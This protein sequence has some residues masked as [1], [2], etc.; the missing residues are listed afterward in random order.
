MTLLLLLSGPLAV[1][2]SAI[3]AI[4]MKRHGFQKISSGKYLE[5]LAQ[6]RGDSSSRADLQALGDGLDAQTNFSWLIDDVAAPVIAAQPDQKCW[7]LDSVRKH[8]QVE[9]FRS[10]FGRHVFHTHLTAD[11][12]TLEARY[13][14]RLESG[15]EYFGDTPYLTAK[16]HPNEIESCS[17]IDIA[18]LVL[19]I[20]ETPSQA[21]A[22]AILRTWEERGN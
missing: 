20:T 6:Q 17:L 14:A 7:L 9:H 4:L 5:R 22:S 18:D 10:R 8:R 3:A 21:A 2:K 13:N 11:E 19:D 15:N 16:R 12:S 1:G